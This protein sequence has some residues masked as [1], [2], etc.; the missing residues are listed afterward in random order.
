MI[1]SG[2]LGSLSFSTLSDRLESVELAYHQTFESIYEKS[3][4]SL[5]PWS[6]FV[7][8]LRFGNGIYWINGKAG[9]GKST[10]MR[11][12]Y[13]NQRTSEELQK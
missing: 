9:S 6:N 2:V 11:Y 4:V 10:L 3:H 7:E 12:I 8:W 13:E 5:K 1:K